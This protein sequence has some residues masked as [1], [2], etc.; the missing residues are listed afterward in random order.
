MNHKYIT[1][2]GYGGTGSSIISDLMKEFRN[3]KSCGSDFELTLSFDNDGISD[4][5]HYIVDDFERNKISEGIFRFQKHV[6]QL[7]RIY[8]KKMKVD[9][10]GIL[11]DYINSLIDVEWKGTSIQQKFRYPRWQHILLYRIPEIVQSL[12]Y[13]YN[14]GY[15]HTTKYKRKLPIYV[16]YGKEKFFNNTRQMYRQLLD[17]FDIDFCYEYLCFD[18]LVPSYNFNRYSSY[19]PNL[20]I[21]AVDRDPRD[22][23]LLNELYWHEGWIPSHDI[24]TY[25]R[26][27]KLLREQKKYEIIPQN[28]LCI[29]FEESIFH[30]DDFLKKIINFVGLDL[31][32]HIAPMKYFN[33]EVSI[34]NVELWKSIHTKNIEISKIEK[35]LTEYCW[36]DKG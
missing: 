12:L 23:Y 1:C 17:S 16:S 5:Q 7:S 14:D 25:I 2:T 10:E 34:K 21:I 4:L 3:V 33:P 20:K 13:K 27:F 24:N 6:K 15:E 28:V 26:W 9:F 22:L 32:D 30:Y 29:N 36:T 18:Q 8:R 11:N 19:F 31:S 35:E